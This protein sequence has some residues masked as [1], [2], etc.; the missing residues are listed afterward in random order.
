LPLIPNE[1]Y[2]AIFEC[3]APTCKPLVQEQHVKTFSALAL[4]CRFFCAIALPRIF[5][6]VEFSG[7]ITAGTDR[8]QAGRKTTWVKQVVA[9]TEPAKS[10]ALYVRECCFKYW[11]APKM[12]QGFLL[13][14]S[15][16][17]CQAMACMTNI[18]K[19]EF[20]Q[21]FVKKGHWDAMAALKQLDC[22]M[23]HCCSFTDD[24]PVQELSIRSVVLSSSSTSFTL[25]PIATSTLR[26]LKADELESVL[27]LVTVRQ[28][29]IEK[30]VLL[31]ANVG[32]KMLL[33][34]LEKLPSLESLYF[35]VG[36]D[37]A[38]SP[39]TSGFSLKKLFTRLRSFTMI[40]PIW[41][42][43]ISRDGTEK[44]CSMS[45]VLFSDSSPH[46]YS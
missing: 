38:T 28:L 22:L 6:R 46:D 43:D 8:M 7:D 42:D 17:Y 45:S 36:E 31:D 39:F 35:M 23:F 27:K 14:L 10:A 9:N 25:R 12:V 20:S 13:P 4:V 15:T 26:T 30:L 40:P 21:S 24:P 18:R 16:L 11:E 3:I 29:T 37:L 2:L 19:V 1:I 41:K 5:E 34:V 44:V 33:Q 32:M